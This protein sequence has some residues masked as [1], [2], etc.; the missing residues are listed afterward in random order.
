MWP[1][2]AKSITLHH[3]CSS[4]YNIYSRSYTLTPLNHVCRTSPSSFRTTKSASR[5]TSSFPLPVSPIIS[6][7]FSV[8][9]LT[10]SANVQPL[11]LFRF[12]THS[13]KP[14]QLPINVS[15]PSIMTTLP[16]FRCAC[17][18]CACPGCTPSGSPASSIESV[19][20]THLSG[21]A[22]YA[23]VSVAGCRWMPSAMT[24]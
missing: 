20:R 16:F 3:R 2:N 6:A 13:S 23:V 18:I 10:A 1:N 9:H 5:P 15:V 8:T 17:G 11:H 14:I 12:R 4:N 22:R 24:L 7:T 21:F 19:M